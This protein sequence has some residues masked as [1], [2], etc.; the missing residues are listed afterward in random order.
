MSSPSAKGSKWIC[1]QIGA[2]EHYAVPRMFKR[3]DLL[4]ALIT[5]LW[6]P[7]RQGLQTFG[8]HHATRRLFE[9]FHEELRNEDIEAANWRFLG[10]EA[11]GRMRRAAGWAWIM[12]RNAAFERFAASVVSKKVG[13][14]RPAGVFAYSYAAEGIFQYARTRGMKTILGQI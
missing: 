3:N 11:Y 5:D 7:R 14:P 2:R 4:E 8:F 1:C 12:R 9:R 13:R 6:T 10:L